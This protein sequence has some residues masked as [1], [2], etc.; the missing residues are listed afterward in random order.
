M[1]MDNER[2][3]KN[4][5]D[6]RDQGFR[7]PRSGFP[8]G[9]MPGRGLPGG[10]RGV[11]VGGGL[12]TLLLLL[13]LLF[14]GVLGGG[15]EP[16]VT[17]G[18]A[19]GYQEQAARTPSANAPPSEDEQARFVSRVLASTEDVWSAEFRRAGREY[20]APRLV[21]FFGSVQSGCG[22]AEAAMGPFYCPVDQRVYIDLSFFREMER[23]L[24][25]PGDF[26]QAYVIA[27]EVGHHVQNLLG[28]L[29]RTMAMQQRLGRDSEEANAISV[30]VELQ[31]DCLAGFWAQ[32]AQEMRGILERGD[33]EE[34]LGAAA[35][36]G[37]DRMQSRSRGYV[38]PETF[39]HGSSRERVTWFR[40]G[41]QSADVGAC[42]TFGN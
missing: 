36:V 12:G 31:A 16:G 39:T 41:L 7:F 24:G 13:L 33:I 23:R 4:V 27:H 22:M 42:N 10:G 21:L 18:P 25:A 40:R 6:R 28:V 8:G 14:L 11:A 17:T 1:R 9:G 30:R 35:A 37:D 15:G 34:G 20:Q 5:E 3:S 29:P 32:R 26:A 38:V 19:P 2:E